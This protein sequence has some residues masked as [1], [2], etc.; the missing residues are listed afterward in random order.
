MNHHES[1][2]LNRRE[3]AVSRAK[4]LNYNHLGLSVL[5]SEDTRQE[6]NYTTWLSGAQTT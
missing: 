6:C 5:E 2:A 3:M 1:G 4:C